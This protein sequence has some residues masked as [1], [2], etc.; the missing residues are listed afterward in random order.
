MKQQQ[1]KQKHLLILLGIVIVGIARVVG[2]QILGENVADAN[3]KAVM[4]DC[5][6]MATRAQHWYKKT[7]ILDGGGCSFSHFS[8]EVIGA[9]STNTNGTYS[10]SHVTSDSFVLTG[11]GKED[12]NLDGTI[13]TVAIT[14]YAEAISNPIITY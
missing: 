7:S 8:L 5:T 6:S 14:V 10:V 12:S 4:Q 2:I 3:L 1:Q 11:T 9:D 13:L